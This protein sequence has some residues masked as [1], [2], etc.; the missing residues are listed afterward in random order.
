MLKLI[1]SLKFKKMIKNN[2]KKLL[3]WKQKQER[4]RHSENFNFY[5][6]LGKINYKIVYLYFGNKKSFKRVLK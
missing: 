2:E 5:R 3:S 1:K 6:P 4:T